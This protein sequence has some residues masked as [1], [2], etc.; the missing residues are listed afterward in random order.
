MAVTPSGAA[1]PSS[2]VG[3][4]QSCGPQWFARALDAAW[5]RRPPSCF[6]SSRVRKVSL[7]LWSQIRVA[8]PPVGGHGYIPSWNVW[9][10]LSGVGRSDGHCAW[11]GRPIRHRFASTFVITSKR[12][13]PYRTVRATPLDQLD[14]RRLPPP[15]NSRKW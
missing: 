6:A 11:A 5:R 9:L 4:T 14:V 7:R 1:M 3:T 12:S 13:R 10:S 8:A 2:T 15:K